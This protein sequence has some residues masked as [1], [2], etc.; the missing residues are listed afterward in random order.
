[1]GFLSPWLWCVYACGLG[2]GGGGAEG[3]DGV[4]FGV[5]DVEDGQQPCELQDV[6]EFFAEIRQ[7]HFGALTSR[8]HV[9]AT[10]MPSPELSM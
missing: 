1:M 4:G 3:A 10:S 5:V 7:M 2:G 6:M 9:Q 8:A